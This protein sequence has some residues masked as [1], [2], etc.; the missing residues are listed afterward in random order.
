MKN[1]L[2]AIGIYEITENSNVSVELSAYAEELERLRLELDE[3]YRELFIDTAQSYGLSERERVLG[4]EKSQFSIEARREMLKLFEQI[5]GEF[6][7]A[8][9]FNK[10]L[11]S[12]G[13]NDFSVVESIGRQRVT[14]TINDVLSSAQKSELKEKV[15]GELPLRIEPTYKF[16][17]ET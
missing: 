5:A 17:D 10:F 1:K 12:C 8:E 11:L 9:K 2:E 7:T 16:A 4:K 15:R 6:C 3:L 13:L 14:I